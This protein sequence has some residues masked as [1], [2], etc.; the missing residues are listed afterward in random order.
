MAS[1]LGSAY[2][3]LS[4][5]W[6][7]GLSGVAA[8][9]GAAVAMYKLADAMRGVASDG[10]KMASTLIRQQVVIERLAGSASVAA[11]MLKELVDLDLKTPF[12]VGELTK[13][14]TMLM[15]TGEIAQKDILPMVRAITD[16]AAGSAGGLESLPAIA[17]AFAQMLAKGKIQAQEMTVQL[18]NAGIPAWKLLAD[19]M[20]VTV[21]E[22]IKLGDQGKLGLREIHLLLGEVEKKY[23]GL[24]EEITNRS[25][26]DA[27]I[28]LRSQ[29][30]LIVAQIAGPLLSSF[31]KFVNLVREGLK[32]DFMKKLVAGATRLS[33]MLAKAFEF[34]TTTKMGQAILATV[35]LA[36]GFTAA[37][38]AIV[39]LIAAAI[40]FPQL[41]IAI[42]AIPAIIALI[43]PLMGALAAAIVGTAAAFK[44]A[45]ESPSAVKLRRHLSEMKNLI[46]EIIA[47]VKG[48]LLEA[49]NAIK[50]LVMS[51]FTSEVMQANV[52]FWTSVTGYAKDFLDL[53]SLLTTNF[54]LTWQLFSV[55]AKIAFNNMIADVKHFLSYWGTVIENVGTVMVNALGASFD[56]I[57]GFV[58][59]FGTLFMEVISSAGDRLSATF[60][61]L[62]QLPADVLEYG[63]SGA[64]ERYN[65][66][67]QSA[68]DSQVARQNVAFGEFGKAIDPVAATRRVVER[69][70]DNLKDAPKY[71]EPAANRGLFKQAAALLKQMETERTKDRV[72]AGK[73]KMK[74]WIADQ[75]KNAGASVKGVAAGA[76][77][78]AGGAAKMIANR[79]RGEEQEEKAKGEFVGIAELSKKIQL[80]ILNAD[81]E[82][83]RK[84]M[85][86][87]IDVVGVG[88][89]GVKDAVKDVYGAVKNWL[90]KA[91]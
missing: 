88:V 51:L 82:A 38:V 9:T 29:I 30:A 6:A 45:F 17:R 46:L 83:D 36:A 22:A 8:I 84:A 90:P 40:A 63:I 49:F 64:S 53:I 65:A 5:R 26:K 60:A 55:F 86:K 37:A 12:N 15:A 7:R 58:T 10:V 1:K 11:S 56:E 74:D 19:A 91:T 61:A 48:G 66:T 80:G 75:V 59:A 27:F 14:A 2:L 50:K 44:A 54:G 34:L 71:K 4:V 13:V 16:A 85:I 79:F 52:D 41:A 69:L 77:G 62:K 70:D 39:G 23:K 24:A 73:N 31:L 76:V 78:V 3:E 81:E 57:A 32:S 43:L 20:G 33:E 68:I 42:A 47:N 18:A 89:K 25:P 35:A 87:G 21:A 67:V 72:E 28:A